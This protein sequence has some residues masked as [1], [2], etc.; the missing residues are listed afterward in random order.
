MISTEI[1]A[2]TRSGRDAAADAPFSALILES[3]SRLRAAQPAAH[4]A[5]VVTTMLSGAAP[6]RDTRRALRML[7]GG[8]RGPSGMGVAAEWREARARKH[9]FAG[10]RHSFPP[11]RRYSIK[12]PMR[13]SSRQ[14]RL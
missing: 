11:G 12:R 14:P 10:A 5:V 8:R 3:H 1:A 13:L 6:R 7:L 9:H 2:S 4:I